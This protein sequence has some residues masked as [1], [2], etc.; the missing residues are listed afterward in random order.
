MAGS[1]SLTVTGH[2]EYAT[3]KIRKYSSF[4]RT[5]WKPTRI[6]G[7]AQLKFDYTGAENMMSSWDTLVTIEVFLQP[8]EMIS[9][10]TESNYLDAYY[11]ALYEE[12]GKKLDAL[13]PFSQTET[14]KEFLPP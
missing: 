8:P 2:I 3:Y 9:L 5:E 4:S 7:F 14:P 6:P 13:S 12:V 1:R 11:E 10:K